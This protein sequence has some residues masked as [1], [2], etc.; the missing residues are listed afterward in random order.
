[1]RDR[2]L[3][4]HKSTC[5]VFDVEIGRTDPDRCHWSV[6]TACHLGTLTVRLSNASYAIVYRAPVF[7]DLLVCI[8]AAFAPY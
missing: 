1:M 6:D 8:R 5:A 3:P 7:G 4:G 2:G